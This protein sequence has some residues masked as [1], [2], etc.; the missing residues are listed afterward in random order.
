V[1][2][3]HAE[4]RVTRGR[5]VLEVRPHVDW[6]KG[7]ALA[8]LL[9]MLGLA[10]P[11]SVFCLY[12]G[13]D[14]TDEDAFKGG[15][16]GWVGGCGGWVQMVFWQGLAPSCF[17]NRLFLCCNIRMLS[18]AQHRRALWGGEGS[19]ALWERRSGSSSSVC[20]CLPACPPARPSAL[21][22]QQMLLSI[23]CPACLQCW[24]SSGW[25][26]ASW[27]PPSPS[28]PRG[29]GRCGTPQVWHSH[30]HPRSQ[31]GPAPASCMQSV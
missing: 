29:C 24:L 4:L 28:P 3:G 1:A 13:D 25:A 9:G 18:L 26:A 10:D 17:L 23:A 30:S 6:H 21:T 2:A 8:H 16:G 31:P 20:L 12:I 22:D 5:K 11:S 15:C 14:R 7:T 27:F 19:S